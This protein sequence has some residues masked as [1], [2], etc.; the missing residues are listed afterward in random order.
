MSRYYLGIAERNYARLC[1][2][3]GV[4]VLGIKG[5]AGVRKLSVGDGVIYYSPKTEPDGE[6]LQCFTAIGEVTGEAPWEREFE[7]GTTL[8]VRDIAWRTEAREVPIRPLLETLSWVKNPRN[9]GF[10]MRGSSREIAGEDYAAIAGAMLGGD[11]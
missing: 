6:T 11:V 9:W 3:A 7:G 10:Y 4:V 1:V 2:E 5:P 8:W